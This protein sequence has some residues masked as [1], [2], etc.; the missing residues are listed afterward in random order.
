MS[1]LCVGLVCVLSMCWWIG[2]RTIHSVVEKD[3][4][5][6]VYAMLAIVRGISWDAAVAIGIISICYFGKHRSV[7]VAQ[8]YYDLL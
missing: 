2:L 7:V 1:A 3:M 6:F 4:M 8:W 5:A